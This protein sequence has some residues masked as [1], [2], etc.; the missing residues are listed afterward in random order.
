MIITLASLFL[1]S[2]VFHYNNTSAAGDD[3]DDRVRTLPLASRC[4]C[5]SGTGVRWHIVM[6]GNATFNLKDP[7]DVDFV[8]R[9]WSSGPTRWSRTTRPAR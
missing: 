7:R 6:A 5:A 3:T 2:F 9:R 8:R 1:F 4:C